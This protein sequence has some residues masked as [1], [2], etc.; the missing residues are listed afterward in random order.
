[1][2]QSDPTLCGKDQSENRSIPRPGKK[3]KYWKQRGV[4][5]V[6]LKAQFSE[7]GSPPPPWCE[8]DLCHVL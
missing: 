6:P 5:R 2:K 8:L 4:T 7:P 1:M 3:K